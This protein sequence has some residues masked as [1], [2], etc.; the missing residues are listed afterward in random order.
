M[1]S[2]LS[3]AL[4]ETAERPLPSPWLGDR[5]GPWSCLGVL[6]TREETF[7]GLSYSKTERLL[8]SQ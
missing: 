6:P 2:A 4:A 3:D 8:L 5:D 1:C 7:E